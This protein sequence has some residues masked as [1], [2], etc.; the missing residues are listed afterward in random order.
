MECMMQAVSDFT[1]SKLL[2]AR[3]QS[4]AN[5]PITSQTLR[6]WEEYLTTLQSLKWQGWTTNF[7][8]ADL[9]NSNNNRIPGT[10]PYTAFSSWPDYTYHIIWRNANSLHKPLG[11]SWWKQIM[12]SKRQSL[13]LYNGPSCHK[14][15]LATIAHNYN[16]RTILALYRGYAIVYHVST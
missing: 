6:A 14:H 15:A 16:M 11:L 13:R 7:F 12:T 5:M 10:A 2:P 3:L 8:S 1:Y 9:K 4:L